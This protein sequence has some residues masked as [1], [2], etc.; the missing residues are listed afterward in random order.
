MQIQ[1]LKYKDLEQTPFIKLNREFKEEFSGSTPAPFIGRYCYPKVNIGL[2]SPQ[3]SGEMSK[4]DSPRF[5]SKKNLAINA[6]ARLRC[7]LV[8]SRQQALVKNPNSFSNNSSLNNSSSN[9]TLTSA[10][11]NPSVSN[12]FLDICQ[13]VGMAK[14]SA[15]IEVSLTKKPTYIS[16]AE[17]EVIPHFSHCIKKASK[18][19]L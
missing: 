4:Y 13:E 18:K 14:R 5:W 15:E 10:I 19:Q 9:R 6:I 7:N 17:K 3:Y 11:I 16:Q 8:N 2:L 1:R 12:K